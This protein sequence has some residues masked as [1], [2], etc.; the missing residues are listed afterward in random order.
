M[1]DG[2]GWQPRQ[3]RFSSGERHSPKDDSLLNREIVYPQEMPVSAKQLGRARVGRF[4]V[5]TLTAIVLH[6][7]LTSGRNRPLVFG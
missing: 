3:R 1:P 5:L 4:L 6:K 2:D 7:T